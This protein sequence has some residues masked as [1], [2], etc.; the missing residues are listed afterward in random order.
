VVSES[1]A[2]ALRDFASQRAES[3]RMKRLPTRTER[4]IRTVMHLLACIALA[5]TSILLVIVLLTVARIGNAVDRLDPGPDVTGCPFGD[6][7]C[8]G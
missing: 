6:L 4:I 7:E 2:A 8:G 3:D 1:A 5:L